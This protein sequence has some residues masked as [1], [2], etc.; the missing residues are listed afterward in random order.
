MTT[1]FHG[2]ISISAKVTEEVRHVEE[3]LN[4]EFEK[5]Y[6]QLKSEGVKELTLSTVIADLKT[7]GEIEDTDIHGFLKMLK[8][9]YKF[10]PLP[11]WINNCQYVLING[12]PYSHIAVE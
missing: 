2:S 3:L 5:M 6:N 10:Y 12:L 8:S 7:K 4:N 1:Y 9:K 11:L